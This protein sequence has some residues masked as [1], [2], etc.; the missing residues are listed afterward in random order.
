MSLW[1]VLIPIL[2]TDVLNPALLAAVIFALGTPAPFR[3]ALALLLGH[4]VTY[5]VMGVVLALLLQE[6]YQ[7][8]ENPRPLHFVIELGI[9]AAL[10]V[11]GALAARPEQRGAERDFGEE[12]AFG[13]GAAFL[14]GMVLNLIGIPFAIPYFA[15]LDRIIDA[16]QDWPGALLVL[17]LYNLLYAL[18]FAALVGLRW[19]YRRETERLLAR[20]HAA[21][22][23]VGAF[24]VPA[25][26]LLLGGGLVA[27]AAAYF[28]RGKPLF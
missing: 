15:A 19:L 14:M 23:R 5:L 21:M 3:N 4:T 17:A 12:E 10:L 27:D 16:H 8:L 11:V 20:L 22:E 7:L 2:V 9:G 1:A 6:V 26:L 13:A 18:P 25:L 28:L 24:L